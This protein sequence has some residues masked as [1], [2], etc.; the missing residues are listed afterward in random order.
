MRGLSF[1]NHNSLC[2]Y[3]SN[4]IKNVFVKF[5]NTPV[6]YNILY[7]IVDLIITLHRYEPDTKL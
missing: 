1:R 3:S 5:I 6:K 4:F 7:N 2:I